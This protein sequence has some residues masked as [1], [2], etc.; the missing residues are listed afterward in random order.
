[1]ES[2]VG[3]SRHGGMPLGCVLLVLLLLAGLANAGFQRSYLTVTVTI[4]ADGS[5]DIREELRFYM[6]SP[7]SVDLY[8]VSLKAANNLA[9]W[10]SRM[11]L[12]DVRYHADTSVVQTTDTRLQPMSPD[13]CDYYKNTCYGTFVTEYKIAPPAEGKGIVSIDRYARPRVIDYTF[14]PD[15]LLFE[16]S[17]TGEPY[18]P[19]LTTLEI[20]IPQ[21][22]KVTALS[23]RSA[24]YAELESIPADAT[25]FTWHGRLVLSGMNLKFERKESLLDE[26]TGFF[27]ALRSTLVTGLTSREGMALAAVVIIFAIGYIALQRKKEE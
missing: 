9:G 7:D 25:K 2:C 8:K 1:M 22:S 17:L 16:T 24:E 27:T 20:R 19:D 10:R 6:D 18:L 12:Q 21:G 13:T 26:V 5:A 11:N 14:N 15:A 23:P 4:A 3:R